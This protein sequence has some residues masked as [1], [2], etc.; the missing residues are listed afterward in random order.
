MLEIKVTFLP[1]N[2]HTHTCTSSESSDGRRNAELACSSLSD[3]L[4]SAS[5]SSVL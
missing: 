1:K 2:S 3:I 4:A 5:L